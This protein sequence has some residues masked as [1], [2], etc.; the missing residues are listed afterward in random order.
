[1]TT[2]QEV[3]GVPNFGRTSA[4]HPHRWCAIKIKKFKFS[5]LVD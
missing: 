3:R 1:M 2:A 5:K 4:P